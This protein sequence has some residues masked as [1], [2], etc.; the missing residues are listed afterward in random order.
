[1]NRRPLIGPSSPPPEAEPPSAVVPQ[2]VSTRP[3]GD[4]ADG[5]PPQG[6]SAHLDPPVCPAGSR[7]LKERWQ[8]AVV[9]VTLACA[10][11]FV[12]VVST[13]APVLRAC[14]DCGPPTPSIPRRQE[15]PGDPAALAGRPAARAAGGHHLRRPRRRRGGDGRPVDARARRRPR[16]AGRWRSPRRWPTPARR[17]RRWRTSEVAYRPRRRPR[18]ARSISGSASVVVA[19]ADR[20][21]LASA[22][23]D[24]LGDPLRRRRQHGAAAAGRGRGSAPFD[25]DPAAVAMAPILPPGRGLRSASWRSSGSIPST[26]GRA[27]GGGPEPAHLPRAGQRHRHRRVAA[28]RP[29]GEAADPRPGAARD[30]RAR[31]APRRHAAR[32]PRG[33]SSAWTSAA[34]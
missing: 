1:M 33:R 27:R 6:S 23:P 14:C 31:R 28:A 34:G 7:R 12:V 3:R 2:A 21:V 16:A 10:M 32:H 25:G 5:E 11:S 26:P 8:R 18:A 15:M 17:G 24:Q 13:V 20:T 22:D 19:R 4:G 30:R 9:R 29:A